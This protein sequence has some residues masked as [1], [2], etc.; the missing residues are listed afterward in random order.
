MVLPQ[1]TMEVV[2]SI[3]PQQMPEPDTYIL[4]KRL[5]KG[6]ADIY[7]IKSGREMRDF[8]DVVKADVTE[9]HD[10]YTF[11]Y[12]IPG[13]YP[14]RIRELEARLRA[15]YAAV[16][17]SQAL[18]LRSSEAGKKLIV[19]HEV[20]SEDTLD[21]TIPESSWAVRVE[22]MI[23]EGKLDAPLGVN[24]NALDTLRHHLRRRPKDP[25]A[26][27]FLKRIALI[28]W[29]QAKEAASRKQT[30]SAKRYLDRAEKVLNGQSGFHKTRKK[31]K[32]MRK[33]LSRVDVTP[34]EQ[35]PKGMAIPVHQKPYLVI[36]NLEF[37]TRAAHRIVTQRIVGLAADIDGIETV[38]VNGKNL[39]LKKADQQYRH[40]LN[41][42]KAE[43]KQ[44]DIEIDDDYHGRLTIVATDTRKNK[45]SQTLQVK[46]GQVVRKI[47]K[48][49]RDIL[50]KH[51]TYWV[52]L[53]ANK[54]YQNGLD[55][56]RTPF[57][58]VKTLKKF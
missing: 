3:P 48:T 51:G 7:G 43:L 9:R 55:S 50:L 2:F 23:R 35:I 34:P 36:P 32:R 13:D 29:E 39:S 16:F 56:L 11:S 31:L 6:L 45:V 14:V 27:E 33:K 42:P 19:S 12:V 53:I 52:L 15:L 22:Q 41:I 21:P 57:N 38:V 26:L 40:M 54:D 58:D 44:F 47:E 8:D 28:F 10:L 4:E 20:L 49:G 5:L 1:A 46:A 37:K 30:G 17:K 24:S 18:Q 25:E